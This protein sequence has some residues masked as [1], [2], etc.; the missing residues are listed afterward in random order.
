MNCRA[1]WDDAKPN[2]MQWV[3]RNGR[4]WESLLG[5]GCPRAIL[6]VDTLRPALRSGSFSNAFNEVSTS[7]GHR[8]ADL[9][10]PRRA[11]QAAQ[12]WRQVAGTPCGFTS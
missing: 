8:G 4:S 9:P 5:I 6:P 7:T 10:A 2:S 11:K 12:G 1:N 3:L